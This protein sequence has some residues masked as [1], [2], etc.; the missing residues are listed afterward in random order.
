MERRFNRTG[1]NRACCKLTIHPDCE[2]VYRVAMTKI[3]FHERSKLSL[4]QRQSLLTRVEGDLSD[5]EA[6]VKPIIAAVRTEGDVA[7]ARFAREFD[8]SPVTAETLAATSEEFSEAERTL[9]LEVKAAME[10]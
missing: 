5:F 3:N 8:K 2:C 6:K 7:L 9:A 4:A 10:F 1:F